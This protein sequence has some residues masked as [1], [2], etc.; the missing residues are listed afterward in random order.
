MAISKQ[1]YNDWQVSKMLHTQLQ[2]RM[3]ACIW[4]SVQKELIKDFDR[5]MEDLFSSTTVIEENITDNT[6]KIL[7]KVEKK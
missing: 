2:N 3:K 4:E 6:Y 7:M 1:Q 5:Y